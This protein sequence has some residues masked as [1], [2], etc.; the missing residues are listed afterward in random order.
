MASEIDR[1]VSP[2]S[3][4]SS[5]GAVS[6]CMNIFGNAVLESD[7]E[8]FF[9]GVVLESSVSSS[10]LEIPDKEDTELVNWL[11]NMLPSFG[12]LGTAEVHH[13]DT[14]LSHRVH[15]LH[16][17]TYVDHM[18]TLSSRFGS[19]LLLPIEKK[20][21]CSAK[22]HAARQVSIECANAIVSNSI[23]LGIPQEQPLYGLMIL[24]TR[25]TTLRVIRVQKI[26]HRVNRFTVAISPELSTTELVTADHNRKSTKDAQNASPWIYGLLA[27]VTAYGVVLETKLQE[28]ILSNQPLTLSHLLAYDGYGD[29]S[30]YVN[31][32]DKWVVVNATPCKATV[33]KF[34]EDGSPVK[35]GCVNLGSPTF[36]IIKHPRGRGPQWTMVFPRLFAVADPGGVNI[37]KFDTSPSPNSIRLDQF[38]LLA[39]EEILDVQQFDNADPSVEKVIHG[40][41]RLPN[42]LFNLDSGTPSL[43]LID[44]E[45]S[46]VENSRLAL[47]SRARADS[48]QIPPP[49][50]FQ[51]GNAIVVTL[52]S[53]D[54]L[55]VSILVVGR[56]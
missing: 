17:G 30:Y 15:L 16:L 48:P 46:S 32:I 39:L 7:V 42:F 4:S 34:D 50:R 28:Q 51:R 13:G 45:Y 9:H 6:E 47:S 19:Y 43:C 21:S 35:F 10:T 54:F 25:T 56:N 38:V 52:P 12:F 3:F 31:E 26:N 8:S 27:A 11:R 36:S 2:Y 20:G 29:L 41:T 40:D 18:I 55:H 22:A 24:G 33:V 53:D 23:M 44:F 49:L 37:L 1:Q 5:S 14:M